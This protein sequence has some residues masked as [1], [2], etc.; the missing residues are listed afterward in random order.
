MQ[1]NIDD[2][3]KM[4]GYPVYFAAS[5]FAIVEEADLKRCLALLI[6]LGLGFFDLGGRRTNAGDFGGKESP[7]YPNDLNTFR[8]QLDELQV[9]WGG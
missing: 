7:G 6:P 9:R 8:E 3:D 1:E 2:L 4:L 5:D